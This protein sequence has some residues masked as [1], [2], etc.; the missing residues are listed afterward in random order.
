MTDFYSAA[1]LATR[2]LVK[3]EL[4]SYFPSGTADKQVT[5]SDDTVYGEGFDYF[6]TTYPGA[7]PTE[8]VGTQVVQVSWE[9]L[10]DL[11]TRYKTTEAQAWIDFIAYRSD[12]FNLFN[13]TNKGRN[14]DR[15]NNVRS[16][17]FGA[18]ERP[19]YI[20]NDDDPDSVNFIAQTCILT[21]NMVIN[22]S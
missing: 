4:A 17:S 13:L 9:I 11:L 6:F 21:V 16:V 15:A 12:V 1:E 19:R 2:T 20:P 7:F 8:L 10:V 22:K 5:K 18:E 14:L 3:S